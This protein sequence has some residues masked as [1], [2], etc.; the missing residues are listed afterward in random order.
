MQVPSGLGQFFIQIHVV[1]G[2]AARCEAPIE[3]GAIYREMPTRLRLFARRGY[4]L[5]ISDR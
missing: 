1:L 3:G 4:P 5:A 2:H